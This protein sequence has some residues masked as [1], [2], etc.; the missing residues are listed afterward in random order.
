MDEKKEPEYVLVIYKGDGGDRKKLKA[1]NLIN[2][3][4][5]DVS[6]KLLLD[7]KKGTKVFLF[8]TKRDLV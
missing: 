7:L 8:K 1:V 4:P 2:N 5:L 3:S 6:G